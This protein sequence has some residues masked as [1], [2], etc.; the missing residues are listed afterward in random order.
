MINNQGNL[1]GFLYI[2]V[3][4]PSKLS[5][6]E[7]SLLTNFLFEY[8]RNSYNGKGNTYKHRIEEYL[9]KVK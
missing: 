5:T 1:K 6:E 3:N 7:H 9:Y 4:H 2:R 8:R